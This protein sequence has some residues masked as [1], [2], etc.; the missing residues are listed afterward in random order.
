MNDSENFAPPQ[1]SLP[2]V[3]C[4]AGAGYLI[5]FV[6]VAALAGVAARLFLF[7]LKPAVLVLGAWK[8]AEY[9]KR[10]DTQDAGPEPILEPLLDSPPGPPPNLEAYHSAS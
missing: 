4:L 9:L 5:R 3:L 6:P 7:L 8:L 10:R 2:S 1:F